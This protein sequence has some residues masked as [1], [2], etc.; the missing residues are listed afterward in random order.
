MSITTTPVHPAATQQERTARSATRRRKVALFGHFGAGNF[1][2]EATLL[3]M[4]CR[5]RKT[6][7]TIEIN[8]ICPQPELVADTY[9]I[10]AISNRKRIVRRWSSPNP[11]IKLVRKLLIGIPSEFYRWYQGFQALRRVDALIVPGTGLLTDAY[12]CLGYGPYDMF[13]WSLTAKLCGCKLLFL[14]IGAGPLYS[15]VGKF[16]AKA[17]LA[18]ADFRSYQLTEIRSIPTSCLACRAV[19]CHERSTALKS[20]TDRLSASG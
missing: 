11:V 13:R 4:I 7:P 5:L 3:A 19:C 14:S 18:M 2:N 20:P 9:G 8:C 6:D 10:K 1:G 12:T 15:R 16:L 17:S